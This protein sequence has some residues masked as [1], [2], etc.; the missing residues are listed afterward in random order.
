[1]G[2]FQKL[3]QCIGRLS[4]ATIFVLAGIGKIVSWEQ[5]LTYMRAQGWVQMTEAFCVGAIVV[6][7]VGGLC[8]VIGWRP[9]LAATL[10]ALF[11][12]PVTATFHNFWTIS[13]PAMREAQMI[14]FLKNLAIFGGLLLYISSPAS[15]ETK[16]PV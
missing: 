1:M 12:I 13:D 2:I 9:K 8:L 14:E 4:V 3:I 16:K 5:T 6:E 11:L 7:I 15:S 10:L